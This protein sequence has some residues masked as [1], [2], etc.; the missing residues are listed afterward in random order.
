MTRASSHLIFLLYMDAERRFRKAVIALHRYCEDQD[1]LHAAELSTLV[2]EVC[3]AKDD[4]LLGGSEDDLFMFDALSLPPSGPSA[5]PAGE[6]PKKWE[7]W[8]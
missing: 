3:A 2:D 1:E 5:E 8:P 7:V 6:S 4:L